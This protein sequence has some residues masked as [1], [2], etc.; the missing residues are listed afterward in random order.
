MN[1]QTSKV[2]LERGAIL[3]SKPWWI[4]QDENFDTLEDPEGWQIDE[5]DNDGNLKVMNDSLM[6][7]VQS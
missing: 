1:S 6:E 3:D 7:K 5:P 2:M 4:E